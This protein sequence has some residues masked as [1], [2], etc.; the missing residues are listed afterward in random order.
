MTLLLYDW[1]KAFF[2]FITSF[3]SKQNRQAGGNV[4][5]FFLFFLSNDLQHSKNRM[6][7]CIRF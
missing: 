5:L 7:I 6:Y 2:R 1:R 3:H 4:C